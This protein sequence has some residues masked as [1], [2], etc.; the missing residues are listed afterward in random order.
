VIEELA[1]ESG[2]WLI[3]QGALGIWALG[4]T[5]GL[6]MMY[7]GRNQDRVAAAAVQKEETETYLAGLAQ[8]DKQIA[9]LYDKRLTEALAILSALSKNSE[10]LATL[11]GGLDIRAAMTADSIK[12]LGQAI[13]Q[14]ASDFTAWKQ[15]QFT[16]QTAS[17]GTWRE[18]AKSLDTKLSQVLAELSSL[19]SRVGG[20]PP[21]L[22]F[23][24]DQL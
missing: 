23:N 6:V 1:T 22:V 18:R 21:P 9:E 3:T 8:K 16:E 14:L 19:R 4:A 11:A 20:Q 12:L 7:R 17:A 2:R 24:G 5:A 10:N 15:Q 13:S